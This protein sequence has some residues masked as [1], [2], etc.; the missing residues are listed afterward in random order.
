MRRPPAADR[1]EIDASVYYMS[2]AR[3]RATLYTYQN[4]Q[5]FAVVNVVV[6][7]RRIESSSHTVCYTAY[8]TVLVCVCIYRTWIFQKLN[9]IKT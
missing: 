2:S 9:A 8:C 3:S 5:Y 1:L 4:E 7:W 6:S